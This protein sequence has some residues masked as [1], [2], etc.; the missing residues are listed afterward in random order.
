MNTGLQRWNEQRKAWLTPRSKA[1]AKAGAPRPKVVPL[2]TAT[3]TAVMDDLERLREL[4][5][6]MPLAQM[7]DI[8]VDTW[9][10]QGLFD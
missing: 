3:A 9:E 6:P 8:L 10:E 7:V 4:A 2:S 5:S 1:G